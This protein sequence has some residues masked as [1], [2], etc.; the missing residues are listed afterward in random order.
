MTEVA[1]DLEDMAHGGDAVGRHEGKVVFVPFGISGESVRVAITRDRKHF[2]HARMLEVLSPSPQRVTPPCPYF[3]T[4]GGCQWQHIAYQAQL[5]YKQSIVQTQLQRIGGLSDS[6]VRATM[7]MSDPWHYRN[8]LQFS[9][10]DDGHLGFMAVG[11]H[12][13]IPIERCLL[14]H[15]LLEEIYEALDIEMAGLSRLTLR[16]GIETG[17]QMLVFEME[18]E[19][20]PEL[21]VEIPISCV[22]L[23]PDGTAITLIGNG[24][25][26]EQLAGNAFQVSASSFFQV[27]THQTEQLVS[28]VSAYLS[29]TPDDVLIDT[30]CGVGTFGVALAAQVA[31]VIGIESHAAAVV[32]AKANAA[33]HANMTFMEGPAEKVLPRGPCCPA[34]S[35]RPTKNRPGRRG[36]VRSGRP[37]AGANRLRVLRSGDAGTGCWQV[38]RVGL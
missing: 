9:V 33:D 28:V 21:E 23:F 38:C 12:R 36:A 16:A 34:R 11:S 18:A 20:L 15:P 5:G 31:Q 32:D 37:G 4:C 22:A 13:V 29:P 26:E 1:L 30:Y 8:H 17:D 6:A 27:N 7:G 14:M 19:Q 3:G 10:S 35:C 2:A 25:I 24:H